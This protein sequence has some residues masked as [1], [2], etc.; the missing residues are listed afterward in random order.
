MSSA[1][2]T[3]KNYNYVVYT[4][5][6]ALPEDTEEFAK[7]QEKSL[8]MLTDISNLPD[9]GDVSIN[10]TNTFEMNMDEKHKA[11]LTEYGKNIKARL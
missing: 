10:K 7:E 1:Y 5:T 2:Y 8:K 9:V 4:Y 11:E 6:T 3:E